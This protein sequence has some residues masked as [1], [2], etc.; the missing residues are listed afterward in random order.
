[1][2]TDIISSSIILAF[3]NQ[4][5]LIQLK[6]FWDHSLITGLT[7]IVKIFRITID[8]KKIILFHKYRC[9]DEL[10][11][12]KLKEEHY[13]TEQERENIIKQYIEYVYEYIK[14]DL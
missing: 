7:D 12:E 8:Y 14:K 11:V 13:T 5:E 2:F 9:E 3:N 1:M 4:N 10:Q 6:G